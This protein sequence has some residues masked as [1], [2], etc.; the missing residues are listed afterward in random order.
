MKYKY[1]LR[2]LALRKSY[3]TTEVI[4][5]VL[6]SIYVYKN[7]NIINLIVQKK[8]NT[9]LFKKVTG[10]NSIRNYCIFSGRSRSVYT[11]LKISR[12]LLRE[13]GSKGLFFGLKKHSW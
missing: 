13:L 9:E 8:I 1:R 7:D 12:I 3:K 6:K 2:D 4:Y 5:K 10:K 11:H